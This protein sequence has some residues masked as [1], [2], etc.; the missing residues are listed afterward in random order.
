M[1]AGTVPLCI[2]LGTRWKWSA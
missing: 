1:N 2:N